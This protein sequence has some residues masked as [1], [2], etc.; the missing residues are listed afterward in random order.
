MYIQGELRD[1]AD[2]KDRYGCKYKICQQV[3]KRWRRWASEI[4]T[5]VIIEWNSNKFTSYSNDEN[6]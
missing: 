5:D 1:M 4:I 6:C 2:R 3:Y